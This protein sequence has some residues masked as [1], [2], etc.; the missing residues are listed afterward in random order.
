MEDQATR[1]QISKLPEADA[2]SRYG[3]SLDV[4]PFAAVVKGVRD[5]GVV[6][7]RLL[8]DGAHKVPI[9]DRSNVGYQERVHTTPDMNRRFREQAAA[10][11]PCQDLHEKCFEFPGP[12][13][14]KCDHMKS[15][16][17]GRPGYL[18]VDTGS[19]TQ[20]PLPSF[21]ASLDSRVRGAHFHY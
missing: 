2:R 13:C 9:N 8:Y 18:S 4:A 19:L 17:E 15:A 11:M 16:G 12:T 20:P 1:G 5:D 14:G 21:Y 7:V 6:S 3:G 10:L